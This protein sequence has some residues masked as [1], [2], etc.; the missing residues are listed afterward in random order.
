MSCFQQRSMR[1]K[2]PTGFLSREAPEADAEVPLEKYTVIEINR[3]AAG[4]GS[5]PGRKRPARENDK[6]P[7]EFTMVAGNGA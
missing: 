3:S 5:A 7:G 4:G 2:G 1:E 6:P